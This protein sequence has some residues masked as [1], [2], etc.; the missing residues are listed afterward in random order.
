MEQKQYRHM[1]VRPKMPLFIKGKFRWLA[2]IQIWQEKQKNN[3]WKTIQI[4]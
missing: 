2:R 3:K 1:Y 4:L